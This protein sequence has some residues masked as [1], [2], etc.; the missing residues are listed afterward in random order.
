MRFVQRV[1]SKQ[2]VIVLLAQAIVGLPAAA[3][4]EVNPDHFDQKPATSQSHKPA[5]QARQAASQT[6]LTGVKHR[7]AAP[8]AQ[9]ASATPV[10]KA[11]AARNQPATQP[12]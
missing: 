1:L 2:T 8:K 9:D 12:R 5:P 3:Q 10:L 11:S 7:S 6:K 4:Q